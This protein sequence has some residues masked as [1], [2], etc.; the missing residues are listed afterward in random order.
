MKVFI[1]RDE[2][3]FDDK[4]FK[5]TGTRVFK[6]HRSAR[7]YAK[8]LISQWRNAFQRNK[9]ASDKDKAAPIKERYVDYFS[10]HGRKAEVEEGYLYA[11]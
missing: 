8:R 1:V 7:A 4:A 6:S 3:S 10:F 2:I 5:E 11:E 9:Y